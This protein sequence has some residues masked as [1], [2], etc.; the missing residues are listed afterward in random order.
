M[1]VTPYKLGG[2]VD[3]GPEGITG[4]HLFLVTG[5]SSAPGA[6]FYDA[7]KQSGLP[8]RGDPHPTEAG[9]FCYRRRV[10]LGGTSDPEE[11]IVE[12][13]FGPPDRLDA[14]GAAAVG[15]V[16]RSLRAELVT[17]ETIRDVNGDLMQTTYVSRL[18]AG[19]AGSSVSV[20][21]ISHRVAVQR[22][23]FSLVFQRVESSLPINRA[24]RFA[25]KTNSSTYRGKPR[26]A[27]LCNIE[28]E[29]Q[30]DG[31][32]DTTYTVTLND[33]RQGWQ[34]LIR[35]SINGQ[36][37]IDIATGRGEEIRQVYGRENFGAL[38]I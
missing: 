17:E 1:S 20:S 9:L 24:F 6:H 11:T 2:N 30:G 3:D 15:T 36:V 13:L 37:P 7:L 14:G 21:T 8:R 29:D 28:S 32:F 27:W 31:T 18:A 19:G 22:P 16:R 34:A 25:G 35:H 4:T 5:L 23:T 26:D 38:P 33:S 12:C 10:R